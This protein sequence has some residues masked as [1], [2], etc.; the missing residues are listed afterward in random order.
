MRSSHVVTA[1]ATVT[2]G[3]TAAA[4]WQRRTDRRLSAPA[5]SPAP[6]SAPASAPAVREPDQDGVV[7]PFVRRVVPAA[8]PEQPAAPARCGDSGGQTK[9]GAACAARAT[10]NGRCHHHRVAA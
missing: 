4:A 8:S 5:A 9:A 6:A 1:L 10:S 3:L 7:L 2:A